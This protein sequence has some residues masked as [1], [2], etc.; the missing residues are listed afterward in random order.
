[1]TQRDASREFLKAAHPVATG[2]TGR[3]LLSDPK[4]AKIIVNKLIYI[5]DLEYLLAQTQQG[6][7]W[8]L[9]GV[10]IGITGGEQGGQTGAIFA[11]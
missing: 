1:V 6:A 4:L 3:K 9:A 7:F 2:I 8:R 10:R 11:R 5:R